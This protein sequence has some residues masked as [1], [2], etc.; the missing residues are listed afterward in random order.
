MQC[1]AVLSIVCNNPAGLETEAVLNI[2]DDITVSCVTLA[3]TLQVRP[4]SLFAHMPPL[5]AFSEACCERTRVRTL[6]THMRHSQSA[7]AATSM[8][9]ARVP[10]TN[11]N[12][13]CARTHTCLLSLGASLRHRLPRCAASGSMLTRMRG[14][15]RAQ[16][17]LLTYL[18]GNEGER[19]AVRRQ[20]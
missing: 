9:S 1:C 16:L 6:T 2:D 17:C 12:A 18:A 11:A 13:R 3:R 4:L 19:A 8:Y 7:G 14:R 15:T 20:S 10:A 5:L